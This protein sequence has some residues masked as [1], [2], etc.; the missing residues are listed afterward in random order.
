LPDSTL[1]RLDSLETAKT[2]TSEEIAPLLW[3]LAA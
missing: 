3:L 1:A 2:S